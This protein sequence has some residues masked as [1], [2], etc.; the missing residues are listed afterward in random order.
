MANVPRP[1]PQEANNPQYMIPRRWIIWDPIPDW[2]DLNRE[3]I[4][5]FFVIGLEA[6][7]E[8]LAVEQKK[9]DKVMELFK[10]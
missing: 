4:N 1:L 6:E 10:R 9:I 7:K 5:Q 8:H 2:L 3:L